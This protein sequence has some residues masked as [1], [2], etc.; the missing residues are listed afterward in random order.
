M[1]PRNLTDVE[2]QSLESRGCTA[3]DWR[4]VF[5]CDPFRPEQFARAGFSGRVTLGSLEG[6]VPGPGGMPLACGVY[7]SNLH[8]CAVGNGVRIAGARR[9]ANYDIGDRVVIEDVGTLAVEGETAFGNGA[10]VDALNEGGGRTLTM[11]DRMSAPF[12]YML[13]IYRHDAKLIAGMQEMIRKHV[14][15][16]KSARG[17]IGEDSRIERCGS[18]VNIA[19]GPN[20]TISGALELREGTIASSAADPSMVGA[21]VIARNFIILSGSRV[22]DGVI[23]AHAF[24]GQGVRMGKQYSAENSVFFANCEGYHGE[25]CSIYAGPYTVTHHKS[26]LLIAG[27]FS[28]YN[29]GSGTNQS[30]HMYKL[31]PLHQGMV[32][33]GAKTGSF[34]YMLWSSVVGPFSVVIGKN[35]ANFDTEN[36]PFSYIDG[37]GHKTV[38]TPAMNLFTVG[39]KRDSAKWP[40]RDRR[41]A[42]KLDPINFD[43]FSPYIME[44]VLKGMAELRDLYEKT[45]KEREYVFYNGAH[46]ARLDL[47]TAVKYYEIALKIFLGECLVQAIDECGGAAQAAKKLAGLRSGKLGHWVDLSG[48]V[49]PAGKVV[50]MQADI[51]S[52]K[53]GSIEAVQKRLEE[54]HAA[55]AEDKMVWFAD[56]LASQGV[57]LNN[58][59]MVKIVTEWRDARIKFNNMIAQDAKKEFDPATKIGFGIDGD[60]A[61]KDADFEAVRGTFEG[62]KFIKEL[63]KDSEQVAIRA[64][65][66]L[67]SIT[68]PVPTN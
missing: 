9:V 1:C 62:N 66:L 44:R 47:R 46:I 58:E 17:R 59:S 4:Q 29:A 38:V 41:K 31:G 53:L 25:A 51:A 22:E 26:T 65:K 23:L 30:N 56:V 68:S 39:T 55:Y 67:E 24:I 19:C 12:A 40:A 3:Q 57:E 7:D 18:L 15:S 13:S 20:A 34:S 11:F 14:E 45:P 16:R 35:M 49:A 33:R 27:M 48:L 42:D 21:G 6:T 52:G 8:E 37:D 61:V 5:V 60:Q 43:L 10:E 50:A 2:R 54:I 36:L 32:L 63:A 64:I 28:F